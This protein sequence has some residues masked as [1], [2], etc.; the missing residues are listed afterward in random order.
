VSG[1]N[2]AIDQMYRHCSASPASTAVEDL[3]RADHRGNQRTE[4]HAFDRR[5]GRVRQPA[6][7]Q[8]EDG[9]CSVAPRERDG[10]ENADPAHPEVELKAQQRRS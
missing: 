10:R 2:A 4:V 9:P 8:R 7:Q 3:V 5:A 6:Q 1:T